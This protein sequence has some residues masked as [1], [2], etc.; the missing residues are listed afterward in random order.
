MCSG[1]NCTLVAKISKAGFYC[2]TSNNRS[3]R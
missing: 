3:C 1:I 2:E